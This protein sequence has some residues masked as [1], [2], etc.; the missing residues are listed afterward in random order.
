MKG[1]SKGGGRRLCGDCILRNLQS[2]IQ[3]NN[4]D[5][6]QAVYDVKNSFILS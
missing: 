6:V 2:G 4:V 5:V 1:F 3:E